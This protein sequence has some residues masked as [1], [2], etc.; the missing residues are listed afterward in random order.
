LE[1]VVLTAPGGSETVK[2]QM[3]TPTYFR[4]PG[5][6]IVAESVDGE[7]LIIN[8]DTGSYYSAEGTA[9]AIWSLLS[10][11][12][13]VEETT[14]RLEKAWDAK[15]GLIAASVREMALEFAAEGLL[16]PGTSEDQARAVPA[17]SPAA[18]SP[19]VAPELRKYTDMQ[20]LLVLDPVHE[21]DEEGWP[22]AAVK[23]A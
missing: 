21:V 13:S 18:R 22:N 12:V 6:H 7:A 23:R 16:I 2:A 10:Q 17:T 14:A 4:L 8:L 15:A 9:D 3:E 19:F 1:P 11:G 20:E 5:T